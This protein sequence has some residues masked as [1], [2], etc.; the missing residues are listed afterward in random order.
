MDINNAEYKENLKRLRNQLPKGYSW[1]LAKEM[2]I[3]QAT[4][5]NALW[6]RTRRFDIVNRAIEMAR[7]GEQTAQQLKEFVNG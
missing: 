4:I 7:E 5:T 6:G 2:N 1:K 3:S